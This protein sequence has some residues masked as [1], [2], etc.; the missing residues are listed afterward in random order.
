MIFPRIQVPVQES[1]QPQLCHLPEQK[2][3]LVEHIVQPKVT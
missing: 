1:S 3:W 2:S